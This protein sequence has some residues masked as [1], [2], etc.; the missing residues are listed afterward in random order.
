MSELF[1]PCLLSTKMV[2]QPYVEDLFK[3][4]FAVPTLQCATV[5]KAVKYLFDF[6]DQQAAEIGIHDR[7]TI[8]RYYE[9]IC[10][11]PKLESGSFEQYLQDTV[12]TCLTPGEKAKDE[13]ADEGSI[14]SL[15]TGISQETLNLWTR[16]KSPEVS[17]DSGDGRTLEQ[18]LTCH[19]QCSCTSHWVWRASGLANARTLKREGGSVYYGCHGTVLCLLRMALP[20]KHNVQPTLKPDALEPYSSMTD[21]PILSAHI[22]PMEHGCSWSWL[23]FIFCVSICTAQLWFNPTGQPNDVVVTASSNVYVST[24]VSGSGRVYRL[25]GSLVQ[26]EVLQFPS[27]ITVLRIALSSDQNKL[28]VWVSNGSCIAYNAGNLNGS[29]VRTFQNVQAAGNNDGALVSAPVSGGGNSFYVGS[30]NGTVIL[31]GQYGLDGT[32]GNGSRTSGNLFSVTASSFTRNWFGGFVAGSY[33]YFVVFDVLSPKPGVKVLRVCNN[34][35][36]TSIAAMYELYLDCSVDG[37][38]FMNARITGVSLVS[39]TNSSGGPYEDRLVVGIFNV[40]DGSVTTLFSTW[41]MPGPVTRLTWTSGQNY[42]Y[43]I[44]ST[45][46]VQVPIEQCSNFTDCLSCLANVNPLC[47]WCTVEQKCSRR[48]QCQNSTVSSRWVQGNKSQCPSNTIVTPTTF[49]LERPTNV[50]LT[51]SPGLPSPLTGESFLCLLSTGNGVP[52]SVPCSQVNQT[53]FTYNITGAILQLKVPK[54]VVTFS[55]ASSLLNISFAMSSNSLTAYNCPLFTSCNSCLQSDGVCGWCNVEKRCTAVNSS[56]S[57][58][59]SVTSAGGQTYLD[60]CPSLLN[61]SYPIP[62]AINRSL[63][64]NTKN[65]PPLI[66]GYMYICNVTLPSG[67]ISLPANYTNTTSISCVYT[68]AQIS[69]PVGT[70]TMLANIN[71]IWTN[72]GTVVYPIDPLGVI[73]VTLYSCSAFSVTSCTSCLAVNI[74]TGYGCGWCGGTSRCVEP[75]TCPSIT[76]QLLNCS[77]PV[78][79]SVSPS[80]GPFGGGTGL[81]ITGTDLGVTVGDISNVTVG[82]VNCMV[83]PGGYVAGKQFV[84]LTGNYP[85]GGIQS[86]PVNIIVNVS[87]SLALAQANLTYTYVKPYI[88]SVFPK[89]G[90]MAGGTNVTIEGMSLNVGN[91]VK[92]VLLNGAT[93]VI[94]QSSLTQVNCTSS[95]Q[96]VTGVGVVTV[97]IDNEV[98]INNAVTFEHTSNP[99]YYSVSPVKTI[100]AGGIILTFNGTYLN[101]SQKALLVVNGTTSPCN[102]TFTTLKCYAPRL[103]SYP[104]GSSL[105]PGLDYTIVMDG[106]PGPVG[107]PL[108]IEVVSNPIFTSITSADQTQIIGSVKSIQ[109]AGTNIVNVELS[110]ISVTVGGAECVINRDLVTKTALSCSPPN[111]IVA[112]ASYN[113]TVSVGLNPPYSVG[114]LQ[115]VSNDKNTFVDGSFPVAAVAGGAGGGG[116]LVLV[117]VVVIVIISVVVYGRSSR[118]KNA[119]VASLLMQMESMESAMADECKRAFTELQTDLHDVASV[120][121]KNYPFRDFQTFAMRFLFPSASDD[122]IVLKPVQFN[123]GLEEDP[124][125]RQLRTFKHLLLDKKFLLTMIR[126]LE[127]QQGRFALQDRCNFASMLMIALQHELPYATDILTALLSDLMRTSAS[128]SHPKLL[129]RRTESV[130]EKLLGNWLCFLLFPFILE[131]AGEPLFILF[132][133][134]KSQL[135]KGP[136]DVITGEAR[137]SLSEEKL[138]RQHL[139]VNLVEGVVDT[140]TDNPIPIR[141]LAS[142]TI[143]QAKEKILDA[144]YKNCPTSNR[145]QLTDVDLELKRGNAGIS[146]RDHDESN[147]RDGEWIQINTLGHYKLDQM[148]KAYLDN[149]KNPQPRFSLLPRH[150]RPVSMTS[151]DTIG[152][153]ISNMSAQSSRISLMSDGPRVY[154]LVKPEAAQSGQEGEQRH[155]KIVSEVFLTR[156]LATKRIIQPYVDDLFN[157]V[158]CIPRGKPLPKPIKYLFDF[159]DLQAA[160]MGITD[161]EV[162]H[163]W[164]TNSLPLRFWVNV[165]KNPDF[166][167]DIHKSAT[168]DSCLSVISQAYIDAC[169]TSEAK[170]SKDTPSSKLLYVNE[171]NQQYFVSES[172]LYE[173]AKYGVMYSAEVVAALSEDGLTDTVQTFEEVVNGLN[174]EH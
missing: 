104:I 100:P 55:F 65:L 146:L 134:I 118:R 23:G 42:V 19:C 36:E 92:R 28:I 161:P 38:D 137:N 39:Y 37:F 141:L 148:S 120:Q 14:R 108:K 165:I 58:F 164:K 152:T 107:N 64:L 8:R 90:P 30:S 158:F 67:P 122:H 133:A 160:D 170:Y 1:L 138:L 40:I 48:S 51:I 129:L 162:L 45:S 114:F 12:Q 151:F 149:P 33:T 77:L 147:E 163:T 85:Y 52:I 125:L 49:T 71:L 68:A 144:L 105:S 97:Y 74:G 34:Y 157:A 119:Q 78:L 81:T 46:V 98:T 75:E 130:A 103:G 29:S 2:L 117:V 43:A 80:S 172:A 25:N 53:T 110:E 9:A 113:V 56:C 139:D 145:P 93:C 87:G 89:L 11:L 111:F 69:L 121:D 132:R 127:A 167:F 169:S 101:V 106:A 72:S 61:V 54:L 168:V 13:T 116:V 135:D 76:N 166:V 24:N 6:L 143:T 159:L 26:Q 99:N 82:G 32:A 88:S 59:I 150:Q 94:L 44:T 18:R 173:L 174:P 62:V 128:K 171:A 60:V 27:G 86:I 35:N 47:G 21:T 153:I 73:Q 5:P 115:Y 140:G 109:I 91:G 131:H 7:D 154:H 66:N 22:L 15:V 126:T 31:I 155:G 50:T 112:N 41:P 10:S 3:A 156:L 102:Q 16:P 136:V 124:A 79:R 142:D 57:N 17:K 70:S 123:K 83:Q 20:D 63:V 84:C 4:I 95:A 96:N